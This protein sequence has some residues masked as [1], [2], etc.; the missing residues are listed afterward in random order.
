MEPDTPFDLNKSFAILE[1]TPEVLRTLLKDLPEDWTHANEGDETWSPFIIVGHLLHGD[2]TDWLTRTKIILSDADDKTFPPF[3][4]FAQIKDN[5]GRQLNDLLDEFAERRKANLKELKA[6]NITEDM[7][8]KKGIHPA[9]GKV[10]L[11]QLLTTWMN[12]DLN[13]LYQITRVLAKQFKE[14]TGPWVEFL[15]ILRH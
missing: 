13:H 4:R 7:L 9:F 1:R 15:R 5:Q 8:S 3:D 2:K 11:G 10:S 6:L 12:H 14:E